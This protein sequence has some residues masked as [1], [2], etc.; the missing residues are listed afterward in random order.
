M[1][2]ESKEEKKGFFKKIKD[3]L[4][5]TRQSIMTGLEGVLKKFTSIN[6]ELYEELEELLIL[7]DIGVSTAEQLTSKLRSRV[8]S[9]RLNDVS[10][11]KGILTEEIAK[12]L[13]A[14]QR[15][16]DYD[17]PTIVLVMGV[18]GAGKTTSI[19]KLTNL[20]KSQGKKVIVAA[21]DTFRAAAID[22]LEVW[23]KRNG[24][25]MIKHQE[26]SDPGAV[27]FDAVAAFKA[28]KADILIVD[29]AGRLQNKKNLMEELKKI[30]RIID[31]QS[32][33]A[34]LEI[35]LAVDATTGQNGLQ[36]AKLFNEVAEISGIIL[37]KLDGTAKGGIVI[38]IQNELHIPVRYIC[39][40]EGMDDIQPFNPKMFSEA[41]FGDL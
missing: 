5:K 31:A 19:G 35:L 6:E 2:P 37:T 22:Q 34:Q 10:A 17:S 12:I 24:V 32:G 28:R 27:V 8:K 14:D 9:E 30:F 13:E 25:D 20:L 39:T 11:V 15:P 4:F 40:G 29:T 1:E 36:Q 7:S 33:G 18:N 41:I 16:A 38:A 26:K 3:S 21:A 23:C